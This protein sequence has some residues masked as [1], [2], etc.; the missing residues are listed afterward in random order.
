RGK[1]TVTVKIGKA[2]DVDRITRRFYEHFQAEHAK[3]LT[4]IQGIT[5]LVDREWYASFMLNRL[6]FVYFIQKKGFLDNN[7]N[8]LP[9]KLKMIQERK[10]K[11]AFFS[12][13][14]HLL[15]RLFYEEPGTQ[16]QARASDLDEPLGDVPYL[17]S[18][19]LT[20]YELE[21]DYT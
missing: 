13:Y 11:N 17:N 8:Y 10:G 19:L 20:V 1:T 6:M 14:L 21:Q 12:F 5:T 18:N 4:S 16:K 3:F 7:I 15:L 9:D 2:F